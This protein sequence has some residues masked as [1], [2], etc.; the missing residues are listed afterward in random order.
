MKSAAWLLL[1]AGLT[2]AACDRHPEGE[3]QSKDEA[4]SYPQGTLPEKTEATA[5]KAESRLARASALACPPDMV[6]AEGLFC[7]EVEQRCKIYHPEYL[8]NPGKSERCLEYA[9]P[10]ECTSSERRLMR[11]C[12][13]R[14]EWPN[15]LGQKPLVL[16]QWAEAQAHCASVD[17]RL[18]DDE[19]WLFACEGPEMLPYAY[20]FRRDPTACVM[21]RLYVERTVTLTRYDEC[22]DSDACREDFAKVD[23]REPA[24]TFKACVSPFGAHD[25]NGNVN[26]WVNLPGEQYPNRSGLKGGWW[27]PVRDR[28]RPTVRFHK[29]EDWGY[30]VG[31]RCCRNAKPV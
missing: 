29:E 23:Q 28:C 27:G 7:P 19:E 30:E 31:F 24:G 3:G 25:M 10:S 4:L 13:D 16:V 26:E 9:K 20:G 22:M 11:F 18:C 14:Y 5:T 6:L 1:T 8:G 17:K 2:L 15:R 21:D 12:V